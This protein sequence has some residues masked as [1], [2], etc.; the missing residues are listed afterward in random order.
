MAPEL[1]NGMETF[2]GCKADIWACGVTLWNFTTGASPLPH[3]FRWRSV[4]HGIPYQRHNHFT[5]SQSASEGCPLTLAAAPLRAGGYPFPF[6]N[7]SVV[8]LFTSIGKGEYTIPDGTGPVLEALLRGIL[9]VDYEHRF[10]IEQIV[11]HE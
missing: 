7:G 9:T 2:D 3:T 10:S 11:T 4:L 5:A 8:A 1:V 6:D